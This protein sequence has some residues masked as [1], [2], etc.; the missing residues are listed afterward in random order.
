MVT[1]DSVS[2]I[3]PHRGRSELLSQTLDS[4]VHLSYPAAPIEIH[5]VT[6]ESELALDLGEAAA[7]VRIWHQPPTHTIAQLRN[8]GAQQS[9]GSSLVFLDS[10]IVVPPQWLEIMHEELMQR[11]RVLVGS[12]QHARPHASPIEQ[13]RSA[14]SQLSAKGVTEMLPSSNLICRR[15][16]FEAAGGFPIHLRTCEDIYFAARM[17]E[18]GEIFLTPKSWHYHLGEDATYRMLVKKE[19]WRSS[20]NLTSLQGRSIP[21][22]E[23]P[24]IVAPFIMAGGMLSLVAALIVQ[25]VLLFLYGCSSI[26]ALTLLYSIRLKRD[27]KHLS[28]VKI[29]SFY[30]AY[31]TGRGIGSTLGF[32][33]NGGG[34]RQ[35]RP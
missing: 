32:L 29:S 22:K 18:R 27:I 16:D 19:I 6:Q 5:I 21:L 12:V 31:F 13:V 3:L 25:N 9:S 20:S 15:E 34:K 1:A 33:L 28:F 17:A 8:F 23:W 4:L 11:G 7:S 35:R 10:D 30:L 24:S 14:L 2:I 26:I